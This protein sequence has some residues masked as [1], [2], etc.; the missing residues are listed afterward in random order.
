MVT[1]T[2]EV[3]K[4]ILSLDLHTPIQRP[5]WDLANGRVV[6]EILS[7]YHPRKVLCYENADIMRYQFVAGFC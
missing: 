7:V 4:W 5:K 2:R 3:E 1:L 6:A